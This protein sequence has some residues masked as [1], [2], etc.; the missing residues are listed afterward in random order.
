MFKSTRKQFLENHSLFPGFHK[1]LL[2]QGG[3]EWSELVKYPEDYY[4]ADRGQYLVLSTTWI[5]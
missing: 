3:V 1:K 4:A 5:P 2:K